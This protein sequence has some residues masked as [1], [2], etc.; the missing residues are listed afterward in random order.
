MFKHATRTKANQES[1]AKADEAEITNIELQLTAD[2]LLN[3]EA[4]AKIAEK[5]NFNFIAKFPTTLE[6]TDEQIANC[7]KLCATLN[8]SV[9]VIH[10]PMFRKYSSQLKGLNP[11]L[12][13]AVENNRHVSTRFTEWTSYENLTLDVEHFWKFT[14]QDAEDAVFLTE[15]ATFLRE[16]GKKVRQVH[17]TGYQPGQPVHRPM[18]CNREVVNTVLSLLAEANYE[19]FIVSELAPE[20]FNRRDMV[21]DAELIDAWQQQSSPVAV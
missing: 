16:H 9:L 6:L 19:G 13:L 1:F 15:L 3:W 21:M 12:K 5:G 10:E 11:N 8:S 17:I 18:Y 20:Y 14:L 4:T 7:V 2:D